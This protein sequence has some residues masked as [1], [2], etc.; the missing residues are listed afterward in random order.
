MH[1]HLEIYLS[2]NTTTFHTIN[3]LLFK[4]YLEVKTRMSDM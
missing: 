4:Q 1:V 3:T 2:V